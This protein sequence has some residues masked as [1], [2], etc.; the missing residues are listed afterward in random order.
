MHMLYNSDAFAVVQFDLGADDASPHA[1]GE[2]GGFEIVDKFTHKEI[3]LRGEMAR[4]F[5]SGVEALIRNEPSEED[6]D[7][8]IEG[9]AA[10]MHQPVVLH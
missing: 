2:R 10:L 3:F 6:I 5:Q 9:F 7:D 8:Y 4:S 1:E